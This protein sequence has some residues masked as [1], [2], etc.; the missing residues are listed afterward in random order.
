MHT[1]LHYQAKWKRYTRSFVFKSSKKN[2]KIKKILE[3]VN[4]C[5][6]GH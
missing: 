1:T 4:R 5:P 6:L 2:S 3:K